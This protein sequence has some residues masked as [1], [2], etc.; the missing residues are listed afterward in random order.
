M[1]KKSGCPVGQRMVKGRCIKMPKGLQK[2]TF[3]KDDRVIIPQNSFDKIERKYNIEWLNYHESDKP[4][5]NR[6]EHFIVEKARNQTPNIFMYTGTN[7]GYRV[8]IDAYDQNTYK[9]IGEITAKLLGGKK[10]AMKFAEDL[11]S[12]N[13]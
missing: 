5:F 6:D 3:V 1:P 9:K 11:W 7:E 12:I 10:D 2:F 4:F 8:V 13:D